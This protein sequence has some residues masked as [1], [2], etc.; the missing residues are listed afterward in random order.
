MPVG[1]VAV[2]GALFAGLGYLGGQ[3]VTLF[4][5]RGAA[6]P[7]RH[8][9][10]AVV[11]SG[12][13]GFTIGMGGQIVDRLI[14]D[15]IPVI[16]VNSLSYFRHRRTSADV[17]AMVAAATR[18]ALALGH[19]DR[20]LLIGQSFG[21]DILPMGLAA[22]PMDL[23]ARIAFVGLVVPATTLELRASPTEI[24]NWSEPRRMTLPEAQALTWVPGICIGGVEEENSLCPMLSQGNI[25]KVML[26]GGHP[27]RRDTAAVYRRLMAAV[28]AA[29]KGE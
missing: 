1:I 11:I 19:V 18:R 20:V 27:L 9:L 17:A 8:G 26:P 24:F 2:V 25:Q 29:A 4:A 28:D 7:A 6:A 5:A 10:A 14:A 12:D 21:A 13:M 15:G 23:R 3:D 22:M 16:G